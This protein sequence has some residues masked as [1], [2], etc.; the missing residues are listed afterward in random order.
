MSKHSPGPWV[1]SRLDPQCIG[2]IDEHIEPGFQSNF[3][4]VAQVRERLGETEGN[5]ALLEAAPELLD[6]LDAMVTRFYQVCM[7]DP[8]PGETKQSNRE[9]F[10]ECSEKARALLRRVR[11][12]EPSA[13]VSPEVT[14]PGRSI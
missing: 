13:T 12:E 2:F 3:H 6:E 5:T 7:T 10:M 11:G 4:A 14:P 1:R 8:D 9:F